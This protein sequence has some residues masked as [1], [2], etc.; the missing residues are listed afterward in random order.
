MQ[1]QSNLGTGARIV[2]DWSR[3]ICEQDRWAQ[4]AVGRKSR[5][6]EGVVIYMAIARRI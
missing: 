2:R 6:A 4:H 3:K 1:L 5:R